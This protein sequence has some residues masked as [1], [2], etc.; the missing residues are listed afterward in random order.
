V[1]R[2]GGRK[3]AV[4]APGAPGRPKRKRREYVR[5]GLQPDTDMEALFAGLLQDGEG[6]VAREE[7]E[8]DPGVERWIPAYHSSAG[9]GEGVNGV[10]DAVV[11]PTGAGNAFLGGLAVGLARGKGIE[12]ACAWG[13][14]A[15]SFALEQVGAPVLGMDGHGNET[16][17]GVRVDER[18]AEFQ[19]RLDLS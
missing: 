7:I 13:A 15:A 3:R 16:W 4:A 2:N 19:R 8:V 6:A 5:G 14:V 10:A 12:E 18:L 9:G 17:N 11:D 1:A